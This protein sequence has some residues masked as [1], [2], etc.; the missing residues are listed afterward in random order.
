MAASRSRS[1]PRMRTRDQEE[2]DHGEGNPFWSHRARLEFM[3]NQ[4]EAEALENSAE[5]ELRSSSAESG[6]NL[7]AIQDDGASEELLEAETLV[8]GAGPQTSNELGATTRSMSAV[9]GEPLAGQTTWPNMSSIEMD[10]WFNLHRG[11]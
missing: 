2:E 8:A 5:D 9:G 6:E 7:P 10:W 4:D 3:R 1:E 11:L